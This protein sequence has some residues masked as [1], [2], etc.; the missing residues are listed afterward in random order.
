MS[1]DP[2]DPVNQFPPRGEA[3][4]SVERLVPIISTE[5]FKKQY[6][7]GLRL[8]ST[9]TNEELKPDDIKDFII[10]AISRVEHEARINITPVKYTD[11][12]DYN[13]FDY[14]KFCFLQLN[15]WPVI[16]VESIKAR[17]PQSD[18]FI[19]F[20][21]DWVS[22]QN[23]V[24]MLQLVPKAGSFSNF[25]MA[26][27]ASFMPLILGGRARWPQ[28][29]EVIYTAGFNYDA[30]PAILRDLIGLYAAIA[31]LELLD[32]AYYQGSYSIGIDGASQSVGLP[33]PGWLQSRINQNQQRAERLLDDVRHFYNHALTL[34]AL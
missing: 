16:Q 9:I 11:L 29:F 17:F 13:L 23:E 26:R 1:F 6:L 2:T 30:M 31:I 7:F 20:P 27:D 32:S 10:N 28:L 3:D 22:I 25:L 15:H 24:G 14:Q 33:G 8:K 21:N 4:P 19:Q 12:L 18:E 34:S 5:K